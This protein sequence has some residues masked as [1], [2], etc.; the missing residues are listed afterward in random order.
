MTSTIKLKL[1]EIRS[2]QSRQSLYFGVRLISGLVTNE[3][4]L[5]DDSKR[6]FL[7]AED[8]GIPINYLVSFSNVDSQRTEIGLFCILAVETVL[9]LTT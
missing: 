8:G 6:M 2:E 1:A 4:E 5:A 9:T 7:I 3:K